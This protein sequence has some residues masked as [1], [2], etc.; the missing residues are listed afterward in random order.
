MCVNIK[1]KYTI[2]N[3]CKIALKSTITKGVKNVL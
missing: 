3:Q 2:K 1:K